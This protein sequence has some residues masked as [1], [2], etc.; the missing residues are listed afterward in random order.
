[1]VRS[2]RDHEVSRCPPATR[3][4]HTDLRIRWSALD[5]E[6]H[7]RGCVS[8][9]RRVQVDSELL[10]PPWKIVCG[11][12]RVGDRCCRADGGTC[13]EPRQPATGEQIASGEASSPARQRIP[14]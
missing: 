7:T 13:E 14:G 11:K 8:D 10:G 4:V 2:R 1:M 6:W 3:T 9:V 12:E 5:T